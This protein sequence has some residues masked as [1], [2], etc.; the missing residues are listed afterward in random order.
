M[1]HSNFVKCH[2]KFGYVF[3]GHVT[4]VISMPNY[5]L[6]SIC[7]LLITFATKFYLRSERY[8]IQISG[9]VPPKWGPFRGDFV[10][11][12]RKRHARVRSVVFHI[13]WWFRK[14]LHVSGIG[15]QKR[16][17]GSSTPPLSHHN[18]N[19]YFFNFSATLKSRWGALQNNLRHTTRRRNTFVIKPGGYEFLCFE[20]YWSTFAADLRSHFKKVIQF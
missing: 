10:F 15:G 5:P 2:P 14:T 6:T 3:L 9:R 16:W 12:R 8:I 4:S 11:V 18:I 19:V 13:K 20:K 7:A 1:H 17:R